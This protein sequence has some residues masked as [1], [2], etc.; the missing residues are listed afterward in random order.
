[1]QSRILT[2]LNTLCAEPRPAGSLAHA[3]ACRYAERALA[4]SGWKVRRQ[5]FPCLDWQDGPATLTVDGASVPARA[6]TWA[7]PGDAAGPIRRFAAVEELRAATATGGVFLFAG[8]LAAEPLCALHSA[9]WNPEEHQEI[10]ALLQKLSPAALLTE[11]LSPDS[12]IPLLEDG[13]FPIPCAVVPRGCALA[14]GAMAR[15][16]LATARR[17][18]EADTLI[19]TLGEGP[20]RVCL[21][22][23]IDTKPGTPGAMDDG[24][25]VAALLA[26]AARLGANPPATPIELT[27]FGGEECYDNRAELAYLAAFQPDG[28]RWAANVDGAGIGRTGV[29]LFECPDALAQKARDAMGAGFTELEPWPQ[30][31]HTLYAMNG[32]PALALTSEGIFGELYPLMHAPEDTPDRLDAA[33]LEGVAR[34]LET[35]IRQQ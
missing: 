18:T 17:R 9:F 15:L 4:A 30:G 31:D 24:G 2:H 33:A 29:S 1:M 32:I 19:A 6:A 11:S 28:M 14:E 21:S 27:L 7:A 35:L 10:H 25:G 22:A 20:G 16:T 12:L 34:Y 3:E 5:S 13:D 8:A 23:H 26:L